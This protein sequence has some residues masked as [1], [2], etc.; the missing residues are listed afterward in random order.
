[1]QSVTDWFPFNSR[2]GFELADFIFTEAELSR[3][4]T[5]QL[6]EILAATLIPY[7]ALPPIADHMD[8]LRQIDSIPLGDVPWE[9]F[10]LSY[11]NPPPKT[12]HPPEWKITEYEVWFRNPC[13]VIKGILSNPEFNGHIDYSAY[14]EFEDFQCR[15]C[16]MMSGD[17]V[18][19]Q[20]V[21]C[22]VG[23][24]LLLVTSGQDIIS[25]DPST[26]GAMFVLIILRSDKT[27]V[28]VATG[29]NEYYPLYLSIG[30]VQNHMRRAHK[31]A[32]VVIG[33]LPIPKG[34]KLNPIYYTQADMCV[35][36]QERHR[37]RRVSSIQTD[38]NP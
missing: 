19:R 35:R 34:K 21:R 27:T 38:T 26:H 15:Y 9:C 12:D 14:R 3:K 28:S 5:D 33:F 1:M 13:E 32:L 36:C 24:L 25:T 20:S 7:G 4:K 2:V 18:W 8:L 17:W 16:D 22:I 10:S 30:N 37:Y 31:N 23:E 11:D 29:Q 6:L